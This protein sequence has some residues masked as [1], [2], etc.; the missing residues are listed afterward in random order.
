[1]NSR[2]VLKSVMAVL[3]SWRFKKG[4]FRSGPGPVR[5]GRRKGVRPDHFEQISDP[6]LYRKI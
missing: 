4:L 1:M 3:A 6:F 5:R 2:D